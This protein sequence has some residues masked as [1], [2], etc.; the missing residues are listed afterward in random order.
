[1]AAIQDISDSLDVLGQTV[2]DI[3]VR[4]ADRWRPP[5]PGNLN[6]VM[7]N[8]GPG[9]PPA[10]APTAGSGGVTQAELAESPIVPDGTKNFYDVDITNYVSV[11]I[12][13]EA[14]GM[15]ASGNI[16][17][18]Y[19]IDGGVTFKA[20]AA[21]YWAFVLNNVIF[22][23]VNFNNMGLGNTGAAAGHNG[24]ARLDNLRAGRATYE[25]AVAHTGPNGAYRS[26]NAHFNGPIT[27][28]KIYTVSGTNFSA[29]T[30][31]LVGFVKA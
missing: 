23:A 19:S 17:L 30:I 16:A 3:L 31:R 21:D 10:W 27:H 1:M 29:G 20:G 22:N 4:A 5:V 14:I 2:G 13:F 28:V 26:G 15:L 24:F 7:T 9:N 11:I 25:S 12:T 6:D 18:R 8:K